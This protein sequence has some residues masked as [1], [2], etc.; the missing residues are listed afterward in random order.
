MHVLSR[1]L[2]DY[3][4]FYSIN[5][6]ITYQLKFLPVFTSFAR[7]TSPFLRMRTFRFHL[8]L[9][10]VTQSTLLNSNPCTKPMYLKHYSGNFV[11]KFLLSHN[12]SREFQ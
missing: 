3:I 7:N 4:S 1:N 10:E 6:N 12:K 11:M 9:H 8:F 2:T 5:V